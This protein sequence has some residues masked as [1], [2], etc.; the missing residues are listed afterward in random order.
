MP[1]WWYWTSRVRDS[2]RTKFAE[3]TRSPRILPITGDTDPEAAQVELGCPPMLGKPF[4]Q[5]Q[6]RAG[7]VKFADDFGDRVE[8]C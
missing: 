8:S 2:G 3:V 7:A 4:S 1:V 6:L 5:Q